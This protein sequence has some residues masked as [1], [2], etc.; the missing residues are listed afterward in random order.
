MS[1]TL[2]TVVAS[3]L[4]TALD[5]TLLL[6]YSRPGLV[7]R[8]RLPGWPGDVDVAGKV[9]AVTGATAGIGAAAAEDLSRRGADVVVVGRSPEKVATVADRLG[10]RGEVCDVSSLASVRALVDRWHG[11]LDVLVHNAGVMPP[12]R[13][14]TAEGIELA[15]ATNV[16]GPWLLTRELAPHLADGGRVVNVS[17]GGMYGQ[18]LNRDLMADLLEGNYEPLV[19]YA[20]TKR[21]EVVLTQMWADRLADKGIVV[22][23]MHPGWA[24][25]PGI[26]SSLPRFSTLLGPLLRSPAEGADT[27]VY[28]A[29]GHAPGQR[30]GLFWHD[31]RPRPTHLFGLNKETPEARDDL[32]HLC[33]ELSG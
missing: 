24:L 9:V 14:L 7:I 20:R 21:A 13:Q 11:P 6:G 28:L 25:T 12:S 3:L 30:T 23:A 17:S 31:R 1:T 10:A 22:H 27:I 32:W 5:R 19:A 29:G 2:G 33:E 4:D 26:A 15:F 8:S 18:R 16:L